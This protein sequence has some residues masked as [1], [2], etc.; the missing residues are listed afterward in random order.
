METAIRKE[1]FLHPDF[2]ENFKSLMCEYLNSLID[3]ELLKEDADFDFIDE[4]ANAI[5]AIREDFEGTVLPLISERMFMKNA[6]FAK[7]NSFIRVVV[8]ACAVVVAV[9][10]LNTTVEKTT[11]INIIKSASN[12]VQSLFIHEMTTK[13]PEETNTEKKAKETTTEKAEETTTK[14]AEAETSSQQAVPLAE[15]IELEF[16]DSFKQEYT[17]GESLNLNGLTVTISYSDENLKKLPRSQY[18]IS[19]SPNFGTKAGYETVTVRYGSLEESFTVRVINSENTSLLSSVYAIFPDTFTFT[20]SN[21]AKIDLKD[22]QVFAVYSDGTEKELSDNEYEVTFENLSDETE[23]KVMVTVTYKTT[24][25][26][27]M[28]FKE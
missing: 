3:E 12:W 15:K 20:S 24:S 21:L 28:I 4:C 16:S 11:D 9:I 27:F 7:K 19:V 26:S 25:C 5:N 14:K 13:K 18:E 6:G 2:T 23:E 8:S 22:M 1:H 10:A 17:V